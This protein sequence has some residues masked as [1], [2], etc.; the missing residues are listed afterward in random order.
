MITE[1]CLFRRLVLK[2]GSHQVGDVEKILVI[3]VFGNGIPSPSPAAHRQREVQ[4]VVEAT[5]VTECMG[6]VDQDADNP[7]VFG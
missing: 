7:K 4:P 3:Q 5:A 2:D 6:L 1:Q